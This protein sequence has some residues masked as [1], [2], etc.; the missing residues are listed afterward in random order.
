MSQTEMAIVELNINWTIWELP[1]EDPSFAFLSGH[2]HLRF[3]TDYNWLMKAWVK[4]METNV[5]LEHFLRK[6]AL[7]E[8]LTYWIANG[9]ISEAFE[10]LYEA[11]NWLNSLKK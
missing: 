9:T 8:G 5:D 2:E 1:T 4:F 3:D 10:K 7:C 11:I 6:D